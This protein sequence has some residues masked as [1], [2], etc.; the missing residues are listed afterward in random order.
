MATVYLTHK[1]NVTQ[2]HR[3]HPHLKASFKRLAIK[4]TST[5]VGWA[6]GLALAVPLIGHQFHGLTPIQSFKVLARPSASS[7]AVVPVQ[8]PRRTSLMI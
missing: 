4:A 8:S 1:D 6:V 5:V 2:I 3:V 7:P